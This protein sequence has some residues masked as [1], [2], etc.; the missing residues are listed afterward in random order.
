[1]PE[2]GPYTCAHTVLWFYILTHVYVTG[3]NIT[4]LSL[5]PFASHSYIYLYIPTYIY[6]YIHTYIYIYALL[7]DKVV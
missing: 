5:P 7:W 4:V 1:M 6:V 2:I 3:S